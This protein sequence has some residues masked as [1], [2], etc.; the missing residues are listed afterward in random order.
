M[1]EETLPNAKRRN[2]LIEGLKVLTFVVPVGF[3]AFFTGGLA[4]HLNIGPFTDMVQRT[5]MAMLYL[6][7]S[8]SESGTLDFFWTATERTAAPAQP[9]YLHDHKLAGKGLN[10]PIHSN[11]QRPAG[12]SWV[13]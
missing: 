10:L 8:N 4:T 13:R 12:G 3:I 7:G 9:V 2:G 1:A 5:A 11:K 6:Y